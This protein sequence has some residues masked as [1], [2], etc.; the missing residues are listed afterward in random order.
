MKLLGFVVFAIATAATAVMVAFSRF[1]VVGFSFC[2]LSVALAIGGALMTTRWLLRLVPP[3]FVVVGLGSCFQVSRLTEAWGESVAASTVARCTRDR[4]C[5]VVPDG[6]TPSPPEGA[7]ME[8]AQSR[9]RMDYQRDDDGRAFRLRVRGPVGSSKWS[10]GVDQA[11][12]AY[13]FVAAG[14]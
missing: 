13:S 3:L 2:V 10:G 14:D 8:V 1:D 9:I 5:P 7:A 11:A 4:V 12:V 6:F